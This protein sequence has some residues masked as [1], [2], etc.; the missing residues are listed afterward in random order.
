VTDH[1]RHSSRGLATN[2]THPS[3]VRPFIGAFAARAAATAALALLVGTA[4]APAQAQVL[5]QYTLPSVNN[6]LA[7]AAPVQARD[8]YLY[9]LMGNNTP[10]IYISSP[11][12]TMTTQ[13]VGATPS[14]N[15]ICTT[16][17]ILG[18]DG[19]LY[20]TCQMSSSGTQDF[21]FRYTPGGYGS[22]GTFT[23]F[24]VITPNGNYGSRFPSALVEATD[25]NFYGTTGGG[26]GLVGSVFRITPAGVVTT[27]RTFTASLGTPYYPTGP[28]IE[29]K[30]GKLY[31][32]SEA[33][34]TQCCGNGTIFS[35]TIKGKGKVKTFYNFTGA[36]AVAS[37]DGG[38][39][40]GN[41][42]LTDLHDVNLATDGSTNPYYGL[43]EATD[44]NF[45]GTLG[46]YRNGGFGP[47]GLYKITST[48]SYATLFTLPIT[49]CGFSG[50]GC[51]PNS[52]NIEHTNGV[53]YG[54]LEEGGYYDTGVMYAE[55]TNPQL[56][57]NV[58]LQETSGASGSRVDILGQG[59]TSATVVKFGKTPASFTVVADTYLS[60][61]VPVGAK[62][63]Y[64][65]VSEAGG[66]LQ[67]Q[68]KFTVKSG[69]D[70]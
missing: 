31:G 37:P 47:G 53:L 43:L 29:A 44:G 59:F 17:M 62:T 34:S 28:L 30:D 38:V 51:I 64:V 27:L 14:T 54:A 18:R 22:Q 9:G 41:G 21:A 10:T 36:S 40:Q 57:P 68:A 12:G 58:I 4:S 20:G 2:A 26:V 65:T 16:G 35:V 32:T 61:V 48:G 8:G 45:Y 39:I 69:A 25:G 55:A 50:P 3:L 49:G 1:P 66:T 11:G 63:G 46:G 19:N 67:S 23:P 24:A 33:G 56:Q 6:G 13:F 70:W 42:V 7:F 5:T 15:Y 52:S 60:A